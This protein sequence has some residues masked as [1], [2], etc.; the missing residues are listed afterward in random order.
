M[1]VIRVIVSSEIH[2]GRAR[3]TVVIKKIHAFDIRTG[4]SS[5]SHASYAKVPG[6]SLGPEI[7]YLTA[8]MCYFP[9]YYK[10]DIWVVLK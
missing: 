8:G 7:T 4:S 10:T 1:S 5:C 3:R 6:Q 2:D 9:K